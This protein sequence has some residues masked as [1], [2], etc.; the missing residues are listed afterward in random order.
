MTTIFRTR[1][2]GFSKSAQEEVIEHKNA[3]ANIEEKLAGL[4]FGYSLHWGLLLQ[5][6]VEDLEDTNPMA[7]KEDPMASVKKEDPMASVKRFQVSKK[8]QDIMEKYTNELIREAN[9]MLDIADK[10]DGGAQTYAILEANVISSRENMISAIVKAAAEACDAKLEMMKAPV[11][12]EQLLAELPSFNKTYLIHIG[13]HWVAVHLNFK[14]KSSTYLFFDP[15]GGLISYDSF[16]EMNAAY[17]GKMRDVYGKLS[18]LY[19]DTH[20][21]VELVK[22]LD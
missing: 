11:K 19:L 10:K 2:I 8:L 18:D 16:Q 3:I 12:M 17:T 9:H 5:R 7:V 13:G 4:C 22:L 14:V 21:A 15:N 1:N 6:N 20:W